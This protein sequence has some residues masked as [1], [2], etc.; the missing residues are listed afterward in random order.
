MPD[1]LKT[2]RNPIG[3]AQ[4][5]FLALL[6]FV[7]FADVQAVSLP[8]KA[9]AERE[10]AVALAREGRLNEGLKRLY[11][12]HREFPDNRVIVGDLI[13]LLG[14]TGRSEQAVKL[15]G[16]EPFER[17]SDY[18]LEGL[19]R[20]LRDT[21]RHDRAITAY[22]SLRKRQPQNPL[23]RLG[24]AFSLAES[25]ETHVAATLINDLAANFPDNRD[26]LMGAGY[27]YRLTGKP[28]EAV[29]VYERVLSV[30][31][32][33][34]EAFRL[35]ILALAELGVP[36]VALTEAAKRPEALREQD[37]RRLRGDRAAMLVRWGTLPGH[38]EEER[39]P[40]ARFA[41]TDRALAELE[42]Q[43]ETLPPDAHQARRRALFDYLVALRQRVRMAD[44][45]SRYETHFAGDTELPVY[46]LSTVG[47]AYL[48][49]E[50]PENAIELYERALDLDP[51]YFNARLALFYAYI[52]AERFDKAL[53]HIEHLAAQLAPWR[54]APGLDRPQPNRE[55]L[56]ADIVASMASAYANDLATAQTRFEALADA[57]PANTD[58]R[59]EL[60]TV[61]R[62]RGWSE[63]ARTEYE[64]GLALSPT[65][66]GLR[67]GRAE[68]L[69]DLG[70]IDEAR[71]IVS[72]LSRQYPE[73]KHIRQADERLRRRGRWLLTTK[74]EY[75]DSTGATFA[76]R[77]REVDT[78]LYSPWYADHWRA[79]LQVHHAFGTF[80]EGEQNEERLGVGVE[81][82]RGRNRYFA[83]VHQA[84]GA[85]S[86]QGIFLGADWQLDD[87]WGASAEFESASTE[88][89]LRARFHDI[90]GSKV[91]LA[92]RYR[93][94]ESASVRL[95]VSRL[96]LD[97]GNERHVVLL[98]GERRL[99]GRPHY[100]LTVQ[101]ELYHSRASQSPGPYF[102]PERD[103]AATVTLVNEWIGWRRYR[104]SFTHRLA[105]GGGSYWQEDF[106]A[107]AIGD[108]RYEHEW[109]WGPAFSLRYGVGLASRVYDGDREQRFH[110]LLGLSLRF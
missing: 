60:A 4:P 74:A 38:S 22:R 35:R 8:P 19:A 2:Q 93:W 34:D 17:W 91:E 18:V 1:P 13:V 85:P 80:P 7:L 97:D 36:H 12:L 76:S 56:Q 16:E 30:Y 92:G 27:I 24:E 86:D 102:M 66:P 44:V 10:Q 105:L 50:Q 82:T 49:L 39:G 15:A 53:P 101:P 3:K 33:D 99:V 65:E 45:I 57:A 63:R 79:Y 83:A 108:I 71:E 64:L 72:D 67:L 75:G 58:I 88:V 29:K 32:Q 51:D 46:V 68:T 78:F 84:L 77:D 26:V 73:H 103:A 40:R 14:W 61:Y 89:P 54:T 104:R 28:L 109:Q 95:S 43:L 59:R 20:S 47:D 69:H 5:Y 42:R 100:F 48:Y 87:H 25:G 6:A 21:G 90:D 62:W 106:G 107:S 9:I 70:E 31:P 11:R 110:F 98:S 52:E 96:D 94:H 41:A 55:K 37:W 23:P 81:H